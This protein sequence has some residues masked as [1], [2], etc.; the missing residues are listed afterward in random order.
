[1]SA[2]AEAGQSTIR[3]TSQ[4]VEPETI[5]MLIFNIA[6][7]LSRWGV[8]IVSLA[9]ALQ[10]LCGGRKSDGEVVFGEIGGRQDL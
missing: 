9:N 3:K 7:G 2:V 1:M 6:T 10:V 5:T 8:P 4:Y